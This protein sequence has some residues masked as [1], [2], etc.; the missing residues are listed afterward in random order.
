[1]NHALGRGHADIVDLRIRAPDAASRDGD[2]ELA[3]Q[4]VEL[5]V[6][7]QHAIRFQRER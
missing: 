5:G 3:R 7:R 4:V 2:L 1:M 6:P